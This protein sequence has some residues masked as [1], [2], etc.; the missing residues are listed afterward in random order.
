MIQIST[1]IPTPCIVECAR[2]AISIT[3]VV[4]TIMARRKLNALERK[5]HQAALTKP[6]NVSERR[7]SCFHVTEPVC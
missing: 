6:E 5:L 3:Y 2:C 7:S 1:Y 4:S